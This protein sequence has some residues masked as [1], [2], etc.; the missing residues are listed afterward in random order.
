MDGAGAQTRPHV[1]RV[2]GPVRGRRGLLPSGLGHDTS[3]VLWLE[4]QMPVCSGTRPKR[5]LAD[6]KSRSLG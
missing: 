1:L 2:C 4:E 3:Y 5:G 6:Y